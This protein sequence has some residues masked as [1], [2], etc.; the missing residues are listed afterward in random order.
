M[1]HVGETL[2]GHTHRERLDLRTPYWRDPGKQSAQRKTPG[3][4]KQAAEGQIVLL[5]H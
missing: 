1:L 5:I 2:C 4:I 3:A